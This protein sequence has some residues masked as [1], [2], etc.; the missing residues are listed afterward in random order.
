MGTAADQLV[1]K[2]TLIDIG[3]ACVRPGLK[4]HDHFFSFLKSIVF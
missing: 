4:A 3:T 1:R 2:Q